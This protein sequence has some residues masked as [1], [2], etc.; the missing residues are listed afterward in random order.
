[1]SNSPL[2]KYRRGTY[3]SVEFPTLPSLTV[4]PAEVD[5]Y[6]EKFSHD[7]LELV[8]PVESQVWSNL[9]KTGT[10]IVFTWYQGIRKKIWT[11]YV[12][13]V[14]TQSAVQ[15]KK[16]MKVVCLGASYN[17][18]QRANEIW[19]NRTVTE[20]AQQIAKKFKL[21]FVG[22][23]S[24][25]R[26]EQLALSGQTYLSWL[27]EY[28]QKIGYAF[29]IDNTTM[30]FRPVH[31]LL[32][33]MASNAAIMALESSGPPA[34]AGGWERT[35]DSFTIKKGDY[36]DGVAAQHTKKTT[37]G[38]NP[39]T[40]KRISNTASPT[41]GRAADTRNARRGPLFEEY[42]LEVVHNSAFSKSTA[43]D[44]AFA[45]RFVTTAKLRGQGDPRIKPYSAVFVAGTGSDTEGY[46]TVNKV[47][48]I[49]TINGLYEV[50]MEV[51]TDGIG[52][53]T[54]DLFRK[55]TGVGQGT[56]DI[57]SLVENASAGRDP[58]TAPS[59]LVN[60]RLVPKETDQGF[61]SNPG[62]WSVM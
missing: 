3:Y 27:G 52:P 57:E 17:L 55:A 43:K 46:W 10:P 33:D 56:I 6:Q 11:G 49:F 31:T 14:S 20:V 5:L 19:K 42:S 45:A 16:E 36:F 7:V 29:Y 25:K 54:G 18:K 15:R 24:S 12:S 9:L 48:H 47:H 50:D 53:N 59:V 44:L 21:K 2:V 38:V 35:L 62:Y 60:K 22:E 8:Y 34:G 23:P 1:M 4:L 32:K 26:F 51:A 28:A 37:S 61:N 41:Q 58:Y 40:G 13:H 39:L 30:Y